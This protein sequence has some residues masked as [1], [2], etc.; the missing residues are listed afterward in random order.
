MRIDIHTHAFH[1][2]V[3]HRVTSQLEGHYGIAPTANGLLDDLR[4]RLGRAGL[5]RA[6]VHTAATDPAQVVPANNWA[7]SIKENCP[8][9]VPFGTMHPDYDDIDTELERLERAGIKGLKFHP[10]F[11]GFALDGFRFFRLMERIGRRFTLM[12]HVG[13]AV[14]AALCKSSP[15]K[16][17]LLRK[18]FPEPRI[19][20]AHMGGYRHWDLALQTLAGT[21]VYFDTSSTLPF[22]DPG[23]LRRL[24]DAHPAERV[25]FGSDY[26][27]FDPGTEV[28][29]LQRTLGLSDERLE[30]F[31]TAGAHL[32]S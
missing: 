7:I 20:A 22:V 15:D 3:A 2:K 25:L 24:L 32:I 14:P 5:D 4:E 30:T 9:L 11:Q 28:E 16:L 18:F 10:D 26:P 1:P 13:D 31:L 23:L 19:I 8:E 29:R 6:V 17:A 27:L 21:D 12:V